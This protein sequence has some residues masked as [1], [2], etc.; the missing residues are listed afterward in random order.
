MWTFFPKGQA[1]EVPVSLGSCVLGFPWQPRPVQAPDS[2][3]ANE[4]LACEE[5]EAYI[6]RSYTYHVS[7]GS[8]VFTA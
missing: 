8:K 5:E 2:D 1:R 3:R 6:P 4:L 7:P